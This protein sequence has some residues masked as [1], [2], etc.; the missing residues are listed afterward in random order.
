MTR[1]WCVAAIVAV[2]L[3]ATA[4]GTAEPETG[5]GDSA[6]AANGIP[7]KPSAEVAAAFVA[8]LNA[9]DED[10]VHGK[11][12]KAVDRGRNQCRSVR[13]APTDEAQLVD[14]TNKRFSSPHHPNGFGTEVAARILA[15]VRKHLCP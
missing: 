14:L 15:A 13:S 2:S 3:L 7:A 9:I 8:D 4:C 12:D 11:P 1:T 10:I 5:S 6:L